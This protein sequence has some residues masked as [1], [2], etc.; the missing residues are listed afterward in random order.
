MQATGNRSEQ[1]PLRFADRN[2]KR[3]R[4][5]DNRKDAKAREKLFDLN[6]ILIGS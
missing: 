3:Q 5:R 6:P 2:E 4:E 1:I